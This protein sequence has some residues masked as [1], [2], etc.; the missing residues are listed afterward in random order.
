[1]RRCCDTCIW[2]IDD[3]Q[4]VVDSHSSDLTRL[5]ASNAQLQLDDL[6]KVKASSALVGVSFVQRGSC[7]NVR[8]NEHLDRLASCD[9]GLERMCHSVRV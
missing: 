4:S 1:M 6:T 5:K 3:Q 2:R 8:S 9:N 7:E